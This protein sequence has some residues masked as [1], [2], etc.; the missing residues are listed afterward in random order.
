MEFRFRFRSNDIRGRQGR[1]ID[2]GR[3]EFV[4]GIHDLDIGVP[5]TVYFC[6]H[7]PVS[8]VAFRRDIMS[9]GK[10]THILSIRC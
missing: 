7:L 5:S 3:S 4:G 9:N 2:M 1:G 6:R 10:D 8:P